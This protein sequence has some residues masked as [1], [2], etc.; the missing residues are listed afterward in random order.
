MI[1]TVLCLLITAAVSTC[2]AAL[3]QAD[4]TI[5]G[6]NLL[7]DK[8]GDV[9]RKLG[10]PRQKIDGPQDIPQTYLLY[11]GLRV[12]MLNDSQRIAFIRI[13]GRDISTKRDVKVGATPYKVVKEYGTPEEQELGGHIYYIYRLNPGSEDC[14]AFDLSEGYVSRIILTRLFSVLSGSSDQEGW[15]I[16]VRS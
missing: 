2:S 10:E 8:Y 3:T 15:N 12:S 7:T 1:L 16:A 9:I 14:I 6:V 5:R 4:F 11:S 13:D